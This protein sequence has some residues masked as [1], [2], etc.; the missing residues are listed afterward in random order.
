MLTMQKGLLWKFVY[1]AVATIVF[2]LDLASKIWARNNLRFGGTVTVVQKFLT[3]IYAENTGVA[4]SQLSGGGEFGRWALSALAAFAALGVLYYAL[5][6][7]LAHRRLL[8]GL[9]FLLAGIFG[10][11]INRVVFG[12][13]IDWIDIQFGDW[14]YPTFNL[15][16]VAI[17]IGAGLLILDLIISPKTIETV[18]NGERN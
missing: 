18:S 11:L 10:N 17:C 14:H 16:D 4:F 9:A 7:P 3:L 12:F 2:L 1:L 6:T 15:A 13:V 5:R 8:S